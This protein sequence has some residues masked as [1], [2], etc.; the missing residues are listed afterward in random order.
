MRQ[1]CIEYSH[2]CGGAA[3]TRDSAWFLPSILYCRRMLDAQFKERSWASGREISAIFTHNIR[4]LRYPRLS[5]PIKRKTSLSAFPR[6][7]Y[8]LPYRRRISYIKF[9]LQMRSYIENM[10]SND[11]ICIYYILLF[12]IHFSHMTNMPQFGMNSCILLS[13]SFLFKFGSIINV[14]FTKYLLFSFY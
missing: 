14:G 3:D 11:N 7:K 2:C 12:F 8:Y 10:E 9:M 1:I 6:G 13:L 4:P 5:G